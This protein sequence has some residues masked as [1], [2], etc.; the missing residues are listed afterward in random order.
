VLALIDK[1]FVS[2]AAM[3]LIM[4]LLARGVAAKEPFKGDRMYFITRRIV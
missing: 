2:S 1:E 4:D 3:N